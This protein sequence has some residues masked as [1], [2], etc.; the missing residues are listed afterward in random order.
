MIIINTH[1]RG[2]FSVLW[3]VSDSVIVVVVITSII[4]TGVIIIVHYLLY[5]RDQRHRLYHH[6]PSTKWGPSVTRHYS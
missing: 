2:N 4:I 5:H 3:L 6:S 1:E